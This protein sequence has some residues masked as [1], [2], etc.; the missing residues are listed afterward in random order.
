GKDWTIKREKLSE[1]QRSAVRHILESRDSIILISGKAGVGKTTLMKEAV[2][3]IESS[4][5]KVFAFAPSTSASR[6]TLRDEGFKDAQ[7]VAML[8]KDE[9]LQQ[10]VAGNVVWIDEIGTLGIKDMSRLL[11]LA[12]KQNF[13][14]LLS[15]DRFQ[16]HAVGRGEILRLLEEEAG[17]LPAEVKEIQ[18]QAGE[19]R[20]AIQALS[21]G[22]VADGFKKLDGLKWIRQMP[23]GERDER[24]AADYVEAQTQGKTALCVSPTHVEGRRITAAIRDALRKKGR[25]GSEERT[26]RVLENANLTE[27]ERGDAVEYLP[28][29]VLVFHQNAKGG[30]VRGQKLTVELGKPLPLDQAARFQAF[31]ASTLSLAAGDIVRITRNGMTAD[32]KHALNNGALHCVKSFSKTGDLILDNGWIVDKDFGHLAHGY[33]VTSH[34]SQSATVKRVFVGQSSQSF[35]ASSAEQFYVSCSRG[36]E[37]VTVYTDDKKALLEAVKE[38]DERLSATELVGGERGRRMDAAREAQQRKSAEKQREWEGLSY[39]R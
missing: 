15:G 26:F 24:M 17:I 32:R 33:V 36:R 19:Y 35:P 10:Q 39:D 5:K 27:A 16:H 8:L 20:E 21:E 37:S 25:L 9:R 7:T 3:A 13:R 28:G 34:A 22:R 14:L 38:S 11:T 4:G 12:E 29:D 23:D 31:H 2:E 30:F 1:Q 18:R 6:G